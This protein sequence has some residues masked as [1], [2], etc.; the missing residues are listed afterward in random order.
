MTATPVYTNK[1]T[2]QAPTTGGTASPPG[3]VAQPADRLLIVAVQTANQALPSFTD[4][5][6]NASAWALVP[7]ASVNNGGAAGV[8]GSVLG[9][10]YWKWG[11]GTDLASDQFVFGDAGDHTYVQMFSFDDV[12]KG[13]PFSAVA[14]TVQA[15]TTAMSADGP[16][17]DTDNSL[18]AYFTFLTVDAAGTA[19]YSGQANANLT[20]ITER[21]DQST[22]SGVGGGIC[23]TTG[24]KATAGAA[25]ALTATMAA[26]QNMAH[27]AVAL[28]GEENMARVS[29]LEAEMWMT[30]SNAARVHELA[31]ELW[32]T[33]DLSPPSPGGRRRWSFM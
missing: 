19:T 4:G 24:L 2:A 22:A 23:L 25:G 1:N 6:G 14:T 16:T 20:S 30:V 15:A 28:N 26:S 12:D 32:Y 9:E 13:D 33:P 11:S 17:T 8:A 29:Q 3:G 18:V 31:A 5:N 7:G 27:I 21:H 10:L